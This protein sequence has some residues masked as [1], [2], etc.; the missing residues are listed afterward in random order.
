[1]CDT[2]HLYV[3]HDSFLCVTWLIP[4]CGMTHP[5]VRHGSIRL[6][7]MT[8]SWLIH[9]GRRRYIGRLHT[10]PCD[11]TE[12]TYTDIRFAKRDLYWRMTYIDSN[13]RCIHVLRF[14]CVCVCVCEREREREGGEGVRMRERERERERKKEREREREKSFVLYDS[15]MAHSYRVA[16][17]HRTP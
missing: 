5:N 13:R 15:F 3:W 7:C 11:S 16:K 9:T 1:M 10:L 8:H 6:C 2:T 4:R 17:M 14:V 12:E